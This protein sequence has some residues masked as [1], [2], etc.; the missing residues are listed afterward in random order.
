MAFNRRD[1]IMLH[2]LIVAAFAF[3]GYVLFLP[4][5]RS[6]RPTWPPVNDPNLLLTE[7]AALLRDPGVAQ[8]PNWPA[9]IRN[10]KPRYVTVH[11][12]YVEITISTGGINPAWGYLVYP[13]GRSSA[14]PPSGCL[15]R[16]RASR[17]LFTYETDE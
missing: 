17:G 7:C 14:T 13:D 6:S 11:D 5:A 3:V 4:M 2:G 8:E 12:D 1:K 16:T 15:I 10:L 9:A